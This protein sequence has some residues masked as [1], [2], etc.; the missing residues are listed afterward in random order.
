[1]KRILFVIVL[2]LA[3]FVLQGQVKSINDILDKYEKKKN[4]ESIMV[5][6]ELL[7]LAGSSETNESTKQLLSKLSELRILSVKA[8]AVENGTKLSQLLREDLDK[9]IVAEKMS[10]ILRVQDG[11]ELMEMYKT[12]ATK[13][14]LLFLTTSANEFTVIS[15]FG[16]IDPSVV[17]AAISGEIGIK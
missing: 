13:G 8:S 5:S 12:K 15:I 7:Q 1:M 4:V 16:E 17:N 10:R 2:L 11:N 14:A 3:P 9:M 6:P